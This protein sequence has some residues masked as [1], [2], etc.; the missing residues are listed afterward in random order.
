MDHPLDL[1]PLREVASAAW[2]EVKKDSQPDYEN[3]P[4]AYKSELLERA[5]QVEAGDPHTVFACAVAQ[6]LA[7]PAVAPAPEPE[8][9]AAE[10]EPPVDDTEPEAEATTQ[11]EKDHLELKGPLPA[12]FPS[13]AKLHDAGINTY[14]QLN[15][16]EDLTEI[17]GVG[18]AAAKAIKKRLKSDAK[19]LNK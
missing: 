17:Y 9:V 3:L 7:Q 6:Q 13:H 16:V 4:M 15:K 14:G 2:N 19:T 8:V 10:V 11:E 18:P 5:T 12:D 1:H